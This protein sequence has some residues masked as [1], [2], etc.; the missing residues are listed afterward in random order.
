MVCSRTSILLWRTATSFLPLCSLGNFL[1]WDN[2]HAIHQYSIFSFSFWGNS[3]LIFRLCLFS[4]LRSLLSC[5]FSFS[6][7]GNSALIFG[8]C[9]FSASR[10][11][12]S[13]LLPLR[14]WDTKCLV[15]PQSLSSH[16]T[17]HRIWW[18]PRLPFGLRYFCS[19]LNFQSP[20][21]C[22]KHIRHELPSFSHAELGPRLPL[23]VANPITKYALTITP[24]A[25]SLEELLPRSQQKYSNIIILR[26]ALVVS[27]LLVAL[28]VPFFG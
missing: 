27:T 28:S 12:L 13:C 21:F 2:L 5:L 26:S 22:T 18:F 16:L 25:M 7:W 1:T 11:L 8:L 9:L 14:W 17:Y 15:N 6:F 4:A 3:A 20:F 24:L 23:Q 10:S 19:C